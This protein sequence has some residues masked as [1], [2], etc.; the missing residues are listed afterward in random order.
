MVA[1]CR[2]LTRNDLPFGH[3]TKVGEDDCANNRQGRTFISEIRLDKASAWEPHSTTWSDAP[4]E[5]KSV[6]LGRV[7]LLPNPGKH[8]APKIEKLDA[9]RELYCPRC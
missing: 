9:F 8:G 3:S 5:K 1:N 6:A 4:A 2:A 7:P